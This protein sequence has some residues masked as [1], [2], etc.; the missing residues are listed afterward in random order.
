MPLLA[1]VCPSFSFP[2]DN[3]TKGSTVGVSRGRRWGGAAGSSVLARKYVKVDGFDEAE[4]STMSLPMDSLVALIY[5]HVCVQI[6]QDSKRATRDT[7][8]VVLQPAPR[9]QH[10]ECMT[11]PLATPSKRLSNNQACQ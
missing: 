7:M 2:F 11:T 10:V 3:F 5:V 4:D 9:R 1:D 8:T 6:P